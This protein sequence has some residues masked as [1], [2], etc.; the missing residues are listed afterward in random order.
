MGRYSFFP[1][2]DT[3]FWHNTPHL[4]QEVNWKY[5]EVKCTICCLNYWLCYCNN[6]AKNKRCDDHLSGKPRVYVYS[7]AVRYFVHKRVVIWTLLRYFDVECRYQMLHWV[8]CVLFCLACIPCW[9]K[10]VAVWV[11][12]VDNEIVNDL[13]ITFCVSVKRL[14]VEFLISAISETDGYAYTLQCICRRFEQNDFDF[15]TASL[16]RNEIK[17]NMKTNN[18]IFV[19]VCERSYFALVSERV[20]TQF[21][22]LIRRTELKDSSQNTRLERNLVFSRTISG[23]QCNFLD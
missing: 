22:W 11:Y 19:C 17:Y 14:Y 20:I 13:I 4:I 12:F 7:V 18:F 5:P 10:E 3:R 9:Q 16:S 1:G 15:N 6:I 21:L 2:L 8:A 23:N